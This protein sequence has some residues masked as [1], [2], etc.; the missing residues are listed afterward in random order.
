MAYITI[1]FSFTANCDEH[2]VSH[3]FEVESGLIGQIDDFMDDFMADSDKEWDDSDWKIVEFDEDY[4]D[5]D[6]FTDLDEYAE[7][8]EKCDEHG[9]AYRLRYEDIGENNF[10]DEYSG[11]WASEEEFAQNF[12]E[13][14]YDIPDHLERYIDWGAV[15]HDMMVDYSVYEGNGGYHIFCA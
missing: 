2:E 10:E 15:A 7:Y 14:C 3:E 9:E 12:Y 1:D 13:D 4:A 5:P 11:C 8:I 6:D